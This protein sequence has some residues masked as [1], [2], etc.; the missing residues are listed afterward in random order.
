MRFRLQ[1][2][3]LACGAS[4]ACTAFG[5]EPATE[6]TLES[7]GSQLSMPAATDGVLVVTRCTSCAPLSLHASTS[8]RY[9][10]GRKP[11]TLKEMTDYLR[12]HG[13]AFVGVN[14][15]TKTLALNRVRASVDQ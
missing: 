13:K 8:T 10:F 11:V 12:T 14:Y 7:S 9:F 6:E 1:L 5:Y 15:D 3:L 4:L 2:A